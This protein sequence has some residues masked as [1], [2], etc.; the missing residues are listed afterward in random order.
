MRFEVPHQVT[1]TARRGTDKDLVAARPV[2]QCLVY[3][4]AIFE[5]HKTILEMALH[6][7]PCGSLPHWVRDTLIGVWV[8]GVAAP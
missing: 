2:T 5:C 6:P 3:L 1:D 8:K 4:R 7:H